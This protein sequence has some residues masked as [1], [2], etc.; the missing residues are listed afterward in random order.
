MEKWA[1]Q[2]AKMDSTSQLDLVRPAL[3]TA[4]SAPLQTSAQWPLQAS[5][6]PPNA[7]SSLESPESATRV[8]QPAVHTNAASPAPKVSASKALNVCLKSE[9]I[10]AWC[11]VATAKRILS[12]SLMISHST[13]CSTVFPA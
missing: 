4:S 2:N 12:S 3:V 13:L 5:T 1:A 9:S 10:W 6:S 7:I 11:C 8:A